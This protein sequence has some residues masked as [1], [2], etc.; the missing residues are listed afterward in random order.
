MDPLSPALPCLGGQEPKRTSVWKK[1]AAGLQRHLTASL[2]PPWPDFPHHRRLR[3]PVR[4][5]IAGSSHA[6][7]PSTRSLQR[8]HLGRNCHVVTTPRTNLMLASPF[9]HHGQTSLVSR[10]ASVVAGS[11]LP[12]SSPST[13]CITSARARTTSYMAAHPA[14]RFAS[15]AAPRLLVGSAQPHLHGRNTSSCLHGHRRYRSGGQ[16]IRLRGV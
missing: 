15:A 3:M 11:D 12:S 16:W 9:C 8:R 2:L 14:P 4:N 7:A 5:V 6:A 1:P 10:R 13:G